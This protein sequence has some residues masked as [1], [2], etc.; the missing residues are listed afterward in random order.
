[1]K[2]SFGIVIAIALTVCSAA[3]A[4]PPECKEPGAP[5]GCFE[6]IVLPK[7]IA[8]SL[9]NGKA[10]T[11]LPTDSKGLESSEKIIIEPKRQICSLK[12][13]VFN[14]CDDKGHCHSERICYRE[15]SDV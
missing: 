13:E 1:M 8:K 9:A 11:I 3:F 7:S 10:I 4:K 5:K 15:C 14:V 12:C 6:K 2:I